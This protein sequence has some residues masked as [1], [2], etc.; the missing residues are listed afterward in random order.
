MISTFNSTTQTVDVGGAYVFDTNRIVTGCT[1][2]HVPGT[3]ALVLNKPGYYYITFNTT[4]TTATTGDAT[5]ELQNGGIAI[6][7][8]NATETVTTAGDTKSISFTTIVKVL[9]SCPAIDNTTTLT[10][11]ATSIALDAS[12]ASVSIT[13]LC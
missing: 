2:G 4:F 7:G 11:V 6:P 10:F 12:T 3:S 9:P 5:V 8:A 1:V 13:K